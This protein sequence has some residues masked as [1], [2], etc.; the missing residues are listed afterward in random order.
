MSTTSTLTG[1][2]LRPDDPGYDAERGGFQAARTHRP[3]LV[4]VASSPADVRA[5]VNHARDHGLDLA[6]QSTGHGLATPL[7]GGLL[8]STRR[9]CTVT[10][11][12]TTRRAR[13]EAGATWG[14]VV[15]AAAP[16]GL[17]P[18]S[19]S[20]PGVGVVGYLLG[21][22]FGL[23]G[24]TFGFAADR[25]GRVEGVTTS[26]EVVE[27]DHLPKDGTVIT[28]VETELVELSEVWGGSL[29]LELTPVV[30]DG[31]AAWSADL[32]E[33]VTTGISLVPFPDDPAMPPPFRGR[34]IAMITVA[35]TADV[36]GL[37]GPLRELAPVLHERLGWLPVAESH[38]IH[39]D[40]TEPEPYAGDG[41]LLRTLDGDGLRAIPA[42]TGPA[43]PVPSVVEVRRLG[44]AYTR[45][46]TV[47]AAFREAGYL[48]RA[49]TI[50]D[51]PDE[52]AARALHRELFRPFAADDLGRAWTFA[53]GLTAPN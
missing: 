32:P 48:L 11:D 36:D 6:V 46:R 27:L 47:P 33:E 14:D 51:G 15:A 24:R 5:A 28:A 42:L 40:P 19:G 20:S 17:A 52:P 7:D 44:G 53:Y 37:V 45:G 1:T 18:L 4:V 31:W 16:H 10:V 21:G 8:V 43:A 25:I 12:P 13:V 34:H 23:L 50:L 41:R 30:L 2:V 38:T 35:A 49:I 29:A 26:G 22:G 39:H 9:M 3:D